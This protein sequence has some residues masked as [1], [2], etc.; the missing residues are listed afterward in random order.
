VMTARRQGN[1]G[2]GGVPSGCTASR[3]G[4]GM[5]PRRP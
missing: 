5:R 1:P 3:P 4:H 2:G